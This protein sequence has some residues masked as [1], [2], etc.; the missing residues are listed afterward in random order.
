HCRGTPSA[1]VQQ[2]ARLDSSAH[3]ALSKLAVPWWGALTYPTER[4]RPVSAR[5]ASSWTPRIRCS[6]ME[7]T[8]GGA[9]FWS[10]A[11]DR[12]CIAETLRIVG[13]VFRACKAK[14][15]LVSRGHDDGYPPN[16]GAREDENW[17]QHSEAPPQPPN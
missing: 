4:T 8:S 16:A 9:A 3:P 2:S 7:E 10:G 14:R 15:N 6:R 13:T 12:A 1:S 17:P 11:Y 5:L